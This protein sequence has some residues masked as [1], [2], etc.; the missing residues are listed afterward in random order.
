VEEVSFGLTGISWNG[1]NR[2]WRDL[3]CLELRKSVSAKLEWL[4]M[5]DF[6]FGL[7]EMS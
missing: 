7:T 6:G 3:N 1:G 5:K 2:I 4:G